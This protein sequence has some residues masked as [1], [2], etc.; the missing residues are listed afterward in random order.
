MNAKHKNYWNWEND[1]FVKTIKKSVTANLWFR[2]NG[3]LYMLDNLTD[4]HILLRRSWG[5]EKVFEKK[6]Q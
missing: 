5:A 3:M 6:K 4:L 1:W 2:E